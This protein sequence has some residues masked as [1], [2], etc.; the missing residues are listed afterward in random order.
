MNDTDLSL[1]R[2]DTTPTE[3]S[4]LFRL[5]RF[6]VILTALTVGVW[7]MKDVLMV[8]FAAI[9]CAVILNGI[10]R[11]F[12]KVVP[13]PYQLA[14]FLAVLV[15]LGLVA[16][17]VWSSGPRIATQF[18]LLK[19]ATVTQVGTWH[20]RL[21]A[22]EWGRVALDHL[23]SSLGGNQQGGGIG[24]FS[25]GLAGS[26]T[27]I[28]SSAFGALGTLAVILIA[29]LYFALSPALYINGVLRLFPEP[30]RPMVR[31]LTLAAGATLWAWTAGQALDM[32]VVG[33]LSGIGLS[34][35]GVPLA[36]ALGVLAGL[37]NFIPYIGAFLGAIPAI[38][39]GLSQGT[40]EG[41][42]VA[43][44]YSVIQF[45]EGNV[46]APLIQRHA[47]HMPPALTILSQTVFSSILGVPGLVL[48]SPLTAALLA[49][50]DRSTAPLAPDV[51]V[52]DG[53]ESPDGLSKS[54]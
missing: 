46:M 36:L 14:I 53:P 8:A 31:R 18:M 26:V 29:A 17:L 33:L 49:I 48:A 19:Q 44:L 15:I 47:V 16:L 3:L 21:N 25:S 51:R 32:C 27:G 6:T 39:I 41:I 54:D 7:L 45:F 38:M 24:D 34:V 4:R 52:G 12:R 5:A 2:Q 9:L 11:M 50:G 10:A 35:I 30:H 37:C 1:A 40:R 28:L 23:P 42:L 20:D 13:I 22:S 43:I